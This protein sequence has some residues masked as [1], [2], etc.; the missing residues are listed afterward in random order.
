MLFCTNRK[1]GLKTYSS[2]KNITFTDMDLAEMMC[3]GVSPTYFFH[4]P[5][6]IKEGFLQ[7]ELFWIQIII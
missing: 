6:Q 1:C 5:G 2:F 7:Q 3:Y 4:K